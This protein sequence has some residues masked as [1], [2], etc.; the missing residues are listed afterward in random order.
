[1][2]SIRLYERPTCAREARLLKSGKDESS[3]AP[4]EGS[5]AKQGRVVS[6]RIYCCGRAL[7]MPCV[8][9]AER[10]LA[11]VIAVVK[12]CSVWRR[13]WQEKPQNKRCVGEVEA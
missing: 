12:A 8:L 11:M 2:L 6:E 13:A 5:W 10:A 1:M 3:L 4:C 7:G 9:A